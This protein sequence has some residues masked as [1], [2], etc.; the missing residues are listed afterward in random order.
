MV[1][2]FLRSPVLFIFV[3]T[4]SPLTPPSTI[5]QVGCGG[6]LRDPQEG[7]LRVNSTENQQFSWTSNTPK[8]KY[9]SLQFLLSP[10]W[11]KRMAIKEEAFLAF[12]E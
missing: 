10:F 3:S 11:E 5:K 12:V 9:F 8:N 2:G 6:R 4:D 1:P 7:I